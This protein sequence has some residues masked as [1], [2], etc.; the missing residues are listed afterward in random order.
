MIHHVTPLLPSPALSGRSGADVWLK[1]EAL[2]P[3]GSFKLRGMGNACRRAVERGARRLLTSSG[4]NAGLAVAY[5]ARQ[6]GVPVTVVVPRRTDQRMREL[7]AE[8]G[9]TVEVHGEVWDD[10]H[11][12]ALRWAGDPDVAL[13]HP[14]D[15][16][17]VW[18]GHATLV[19]EVLA[20]GVAPDA[21]VV[22]VGGG[23]L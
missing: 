21:V 10:A 9:A 1:M 15:H 5:A 13:I 22:A 6:L 12:H 20:R 11:A 4:G 14:F 23:G 8:Q 18:E 19:D 3:S 17:D 2:Q 16:P 7:I